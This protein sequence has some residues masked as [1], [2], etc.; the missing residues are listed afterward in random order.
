MS[1]WQVSSCS[2][3]DLS[4]VRNCLNLRETADTYVILLESI[5]L[6]EAGHV[7]L[8]S[9]G[10]N[11]IYSYDV[12]KNTGE[13]F[14]Y[15][16]KYVPH[17]AG[18]F[19]LSKKLVC[20]NHGD[21]TIVIWRDSI[22]ECSHIFTADA[23][24]PV[25]SKSWYVSLKESP[26]CEYAIGFKNHDLHVWKVNPDGDTLTDKF[27]EHVTI[28]DAHRG[29]IWATT[30]GPDSRHFVTRGC[31]DCGSHDGY[32]TQMLNYKCR[33][34]RKICVWNVDGKCISVIHCARGP[35]TDVS[36][37]PCGQWI[38]L[39]HAGSHLSL[40]QAFGH[41]EKWCR[42]WFEH[43]SFRFSPNGKL[44]LV[45]SQIAFVEIICPESGRT[46]G[47]CEVDQHILHVRWSLD[48]ESIYV[49]TRNYTFV[50]TRPM[51]IALTGLF[52]QSSVLF[53]EMQVQW[54]FDQR[55]WTRVDQ[56]LS[57]QLDEEDTSPEARPKRLCI[58]HT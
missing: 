41:E 1:R 51:L 26:D 36:W 28:K 40:R 48:S 32:G 38:L 8:M 43:I 11:G 31:D 13:V 34:D 17:S 5:V 49:M 9:C 12:I 21:Q 27:K 35:V 55:V 14:Q 30:W 45:C 20:V 15:P 7:W 3:I 44:I 57:G 19:A 10:K 47:V 50:L 33:H 29:R 22:L 56:F 42:R 18:A 53:S 58:R 46:V 23:L 25:T 16:T 4:I 52:N 6:N 39:G 2:N 54:M 37:S 24:F